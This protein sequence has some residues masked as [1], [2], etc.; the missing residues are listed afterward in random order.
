MTHFAYQW[1]N[2]RLTLVRP[3]KRPRKE[4]E[5]QTNQGRLLS[6]V[7]AIDSESSHKKRTLL[8]VSLIDAGSASKI[9]LCIASELTCSS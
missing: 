1:Y 3:R 6:Q 2:N 5:Q 9:Q 8:Q 4:S 7:Q